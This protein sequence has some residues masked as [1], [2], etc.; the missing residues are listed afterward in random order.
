LTNQK[1][2]TQRSTEIQYRNGHEAAAASLSARLPNR[3]PI[4][5]NDRLRPDID[6]RLVL[7]KDL[8]PGVALVDPA[9]DSARWA[10]AAAAASP[11]GLR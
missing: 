8:P 1:P 3:P 10:G 7:G 2:F 4:V 5:R 11:G 6:V 9:A